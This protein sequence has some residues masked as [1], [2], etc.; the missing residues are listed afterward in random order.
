MITY[1]FKQFIFGLL[2]LV[3]AASPIQSAI[4]LDFDRD[5][6]A[7]LMD[8]QQV[9]MQSTNVVD[10]QAIE[11]CQS[12]QEN[13]CINQIHLGCVAQFSSSMF[14]NPYAFIASAIASR[15]LKFSIGNDVVRTRYPELIIRPPRT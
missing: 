10:R 2:V 14:Q 1:F 11:S 9:P 15:K 3:I 7:V 8:C 6:H 5:D 12:N 4:A 13:P